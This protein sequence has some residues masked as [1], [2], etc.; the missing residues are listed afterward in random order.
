MS[1]IRIHDLWLKNS[2]AAEEV[3]NYLTHSDA[4]RDATLTFSVGMHG[5]FDIEL[6]VELNDDHP[7]S[8]SVETDIHEVLIQ[9]RLDAVQCLILKSL[10]WKF[11]SP[12]QTSKLKELLEAKKI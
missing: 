12:A 7:H 3:R 6:M 5:A 9:A 8:D 4:V 11:S 1:V 10:A 2:K